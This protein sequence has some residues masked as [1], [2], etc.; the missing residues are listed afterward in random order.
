M[1]D[2]VKARTKDIMFIKKSKCI[3][4]KEGAGELKHE[5]ARE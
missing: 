1:I 3:L 2:Q 5:R 4:K